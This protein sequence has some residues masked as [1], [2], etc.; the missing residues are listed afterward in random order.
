M[1]A[2]I[3][4]PTLF[5]LRNDTV[6]VAICPVNGLLLLLEAA[7]LLWL[8]SLC[9]SNRA[10]FR[11]SDNTCFIV[12]VKMAASFS[13]ST[14]LTTSVHNRWSVTFRHCRILCNN[15]LRCCSSAVI[16]SFRILGFFGSIVT[17]ECS[18][19]GIIGSA[20]IELDDDALF[21][22][23]SFTFRAS[24]AS[25]VIVDIIAVD[26]DD[27]S[28][29]SETL[30]A[31]VFK[32]LDRRVVVMDAD[33]EDAGTLGVVAAVVVV[34]VVVAVVDT[35]AVVIAAVEYTTLELELDVE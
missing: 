24:V 6:V 14:L 11:A 32:V 18:V 16:S 2:F 12:S 28:T 3:R 23:S 25:T 33:D 5:P 8:P 31:L 17:V 15:I 27:G 34:V 22:T 9:C 20:G 10:C 19:A 35:A 30:V 26:D 13:S 21:T 7:F 4:F 1:A 29:A